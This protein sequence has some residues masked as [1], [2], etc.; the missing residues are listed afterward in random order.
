[1]NYCPKCG[2]QINGRFCSNCG[3]DTQQEDRPSFLVRVKELTQKV[4]EWVKRRKLLVLISGC[5]MV[6]LSVAIIVSV[7]LSSIFRVGKVNNIE[8]G[9]TKEQVVDILGKPTEISENENVYC[10]YEKKAVKKIE[11]INGTF[12]DMLDMDE[13]IREEEFEDSFEDSFEEAEGEYSEL[14]ELTFK[15][16]VVNFSDDEVAEV[17]FDKNHKYVEMEYYTSA[18]EKEVKKLQFADNGLEI[19]KVITTEE[20]GNSQVEYQFSSANEGIEYTAR[21]KDGSY[22]LG[23]VNPPLDNVVEQRNKSGLFQSCAKTEKVWSA[24]IKWAR[25]FCENDEKKTQ[26]EKNQKANSHFIIKD[27][28]LT[29]W[30]GERKEIV[31]PEG[32]TAIADYAFGDV[33]SNTKSHKIEKI[34]IPDSVQTI[35]SSAFWRL[36][37]LKYNEYRNAYYLGNDNNPYLYLHQAIAEKK[38]VVEIEIHADTKIISTGFCEEI[39]CAVILPEGMTSISEK[40]FSDCSNLISITIPESVTSIGEEAFIGC[41][42]LVEVYNKSSLEIIAGST[43]NGEVG[44][45]A[46]E[47]YTEPY[48]SKITTENGYIIYANNTHKVLLAYVEEK[49]A[50]T[51]PNG[52]TRIGTRAFSYCENLTSVAIPDSVTSIGESAFEGCYYLTN[53]IIPDSVTSIG[54]R[55]FEGTGY[56]RNAANWEDGVLYIGKHLI[57]VGLPYYDEEGYYQGEQTVAGEYQ[58]KAGTRCIGDRAFE[59]CGNLTSVVIPN[60]VTSIGAYAFSKCPLTSIEIPNSVTNIGFGAFEDCRNLTMIKIPDSVTNIGAYAFYECPLTNVEIGN[61]VTSIGEGAFDTIYNLTNITVSE[62]NTAYKSIDGNLYTKDGATLIKFAIAKEERSFIIPNDVINIGD[63]AFHYCWELGSIVIG[64]GV[65]SIGDSAFYNC[66]NLTSIVIGNGVTS[67]EAYA[68]S[69]CDDLTSV[70]YKGNAEEWGV[71]AIADGNDDLTSAT[72][73]Y[74]IENEEDVPTDGGN[75]WHYDTDGGIAIW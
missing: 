41:Y 14:E 42:R 8:L 40:M 23:K 16:I 7:S 48:E 50:L 65:T 29:D 75:Y 24:N 71:I 30:W 21:F 47:I 60:S 4:W 62:N 57:A 37:K 44:R 11:K 63:R 20:G 25:D 66:D 61:G 9:M 43:G 64:D 26:F 73:Y 51:L 32:V 69:D 52:I 54:W 49:E 45:Y 19:A 17:F 33:N 3:Y 13:D 39:F 10:W 31:I 74:Y 55:A 38:D 67:I 27:G 28:V 56:Y 15:A 36:K 1:M 59:Y 58:I 46:L 18:E 5:I 12:D 53:I 6:F 34:T 70:Y 2:S 72:R 35:S 68:F 22:L